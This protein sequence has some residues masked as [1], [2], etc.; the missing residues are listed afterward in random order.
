VFTKIGPPAPG[1]RPR[2]KNGF[3]AWL[4]EASL[5][6]SLTGLPRV[7]GLSKAKAQEIAQR[8]AAGEAAEEEA[9]HPWRGIPKADLTDEQR[10]AA[11][12]Q[13]H[14][15]DAERRAGRD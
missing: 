13:I 4:W 9:H 12:R 6:S 2:K 1:D 8:V 3:F 7:F 11:A 14:Q 5:F 10:E 15:E